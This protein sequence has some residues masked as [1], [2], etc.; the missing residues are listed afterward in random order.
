M[1]GFFFLEEVLLDFAA[2]IN[3]KPKTDN[4]IIFAFGNPRTGFAASKHV[5]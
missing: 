3:L 2:W 5:Y 1:R 4:S